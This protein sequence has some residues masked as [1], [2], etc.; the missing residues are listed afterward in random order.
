MTSLDD[1]DL[2]PETVEENS[3]TW[4]RTK[5]DAHSFQW[6]RPM[7][8]DE[9]EWDADEISLV[10]V[11]EPSRVVSLQFIDG[12]WY[13]EGAETAGPDYHRPGFTE[14]IGGEYSVS[15]DDLQKATDKVRK[16]IRQLS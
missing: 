9:Y 2:P 10:G 12:Q 1:S 6:V 15:T 8:P 7:D 13:I 11:D 16:F 14:V 3:R 5:L 4:K